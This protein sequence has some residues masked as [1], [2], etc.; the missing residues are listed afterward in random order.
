MTTE[1]RNRLYIFGA[2]GSGTTTLGARIAEEVGV[3]HVDCDDHYWA[4]TDPPFTL[5]R[6]PPERVRSMAKALGP[7]GWALSG[8]CNNWGGALIERA[9]LIVFVTLPTPERLERL[10]LRERRR[11]GARIDPGGDM[12]EIHRNFMA[13]AAGYDDPE[14][15]GRN[16]AAHDAWLAAQTTPV[17]RVDARQSVDASIAQILAMLRVVS[18]PGS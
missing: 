14:F 5:K 9:R 3:V 13:W 12:H 18:A 6:S 7:G 16:L 15:E 8:A 17:R 4:P 11:F 2:S 10:A 1:A